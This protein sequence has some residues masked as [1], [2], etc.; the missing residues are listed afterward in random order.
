MAVVT[1]LGLY[2]GPRGLY[3]SFAGKVLGAV[4]DTV[5]AGVGKKRRYP[6]WILINNK[7]FRVDSAEEERQLLQ[8]MADRAN[9]DAK[10]AEAL[11][12]S[13]I[14]QVARKRAI[15]IR[16]RIPEVANR[17]TEWLAQLIAEDEEIIALLN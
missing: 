2:G 3:G 7:R 1:R 4:E 17:E 5:I 11:G 14:A 13:S 15:R 6:R 10:L 16:K 8:A 9:D 12:D